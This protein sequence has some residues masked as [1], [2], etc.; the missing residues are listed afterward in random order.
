[1][2]T[3]LCRC[4]LVSSPA[5]YS[6]ETRPCNQCIDR[7]FY[8]QHPEF[9]VSEHFPDN[10]VSAGLSPVDRDLCVIIYITSFILLGIKGMF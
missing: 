5:T 3:S 9:T 7:V 6:S 10:K 8:K 1:M 4:P 2:N